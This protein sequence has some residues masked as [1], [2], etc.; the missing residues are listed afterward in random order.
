MIIDCKLLANDL[1]NTLEKEIKKLNKELRI[2][3]IYFDNS[4]ETEYYF[5]NIQNK[6][7]SMGIKAVL[8][9][10]NVNTTKEQDFITLINYLNDEKEVNGIII[11]MPL[12]THISKDKVSEVLS[13]KKDLDCI[14]YNNIG[15]LFSN[16]NIIS[17]C[18]ASSIMYILDSINI[19]FVGKNVVIIGRSDIVGKPLMHLLL[20]KSATVTMTHS[21]TNDLENICNKADILCVAIG[22]AEFIG[23]NYIKE[24]A[25]VIDAGINVLDDGSVIGDIKFDEVEK[26]ASYITKVPSGVGRITTLMLFY[27]L[28]KLVQIQ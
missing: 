19:D 9:R 10:L 2:D 8:H 15:K 21:K 25:I 13:Y 5:L 6:A 22:S 27:N 17:P 28:I 7:E 20:Q 16:Y 23:A 4:L 24:G 11:Q 3:L 12:P 26:K 18:T 1:Q 14:S